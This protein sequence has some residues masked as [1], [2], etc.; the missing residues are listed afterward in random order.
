MRPAD[1][2]HADSAAIT[3]GLSQ[4]PAKQSIP[5]IVQ[6]A[7]TFVARTLRSLGSVPAARMDIGR[8]EFQ[9]EGDSLDNSGPSAR[10]KHGD[11]Q[12]VMGT[13]G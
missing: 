11:G 8:S 7:H 12:V 13:S 4:G 5:E 10:I 3:E 6:S 9:I 2:R 1:Q